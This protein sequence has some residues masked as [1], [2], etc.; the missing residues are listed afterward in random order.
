LLALSRDAMTIVDVN[1]QA[2]FTTDIHWIHRNFKGLLGTIC[3]F[4]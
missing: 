3:I 2:I 1:A 4:L